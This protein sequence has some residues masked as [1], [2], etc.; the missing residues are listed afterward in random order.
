MKWLPRRSARLVLRLVSVAA[1]CAAA[2]CNPAAEIC[3]LLG[4]G[5]SAAPV[6]SPGKFSYYSIVDFANPP[7]NENDFCFS[8]DTSCI[9][10]VQNNLASNLQTDKWT[11]N[12]GVTEAIVNNAWTAD[13]T[14]TN[15]IGETANLLYVSSH[16]A[17]LNGS[18]AEVCLRNCNDSEFGN[19]YAFGPSDIPNSWSGPTWVVFDACDVVQANVG[20]EGLFGGSLHGILGWNNGTNGLTDDGQTVFARMI[21]GYSTA[22]D[23][24]D[25]AVAEGGDASSA[26]ALVPTSN[27]SDPIEAKGGPHYGY[28]GDT[29]P[30]YFSYSSGSLQPSIATLSSAPTSTY[31]LIAEPMNETYWYNF[32]GGSSVPS[33][34]IHPTGNEDLYENPY[35]YV[36]HYLASGGLYA[37]APSTDTAK[38]F[39]QS[40]ALQYAISWIGS[41]G[42]GLP[43]DAVLTYAGAET[44]APTTAAATTDQ[45][46]P[47]NRQYLFIWRHDASALFGSDKIQINIDDAGSLTKYTETVS[48]YNTVC[49]CTIQHVIVYYAAPWIPEYHV[50]VY[51]RLWRTVGAP[52]QSVNPTTAFSTYALCGSGMGDTQSIA[53][54]CGIAQSAGKT[55]FFDEVSNTVSSGE[56]I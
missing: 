55:L 11:L 9:Y 21:N 7:Y 20:W 33:E 40:D 18:Q 53:V 46:Y 6:D 3:Q 34:T 5:N 10:D 15:I 25:A 29:N 8:G 1:L 35:V 14:A 26:S 44:M 36:D 45:P 50:H 47:A 24:W 17:V 56:G 19:D 42:G 30:V 54:P 13:P 38:G 49:R 39:S 32:Y 12:N 43:S 48:T 16:G 4:C 37:E 2:G 51:S 23:A 52:L 22:L 28:D 27:E 31:S 41:N